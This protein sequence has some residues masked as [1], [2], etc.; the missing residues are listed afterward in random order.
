VGVP[1]GV[2][3]LKT[4]EKRLHRSKKGDTQAAINSNTYN[5]T[6]GLDI[7]WVRLS[8]RE[9]GLN[10]QDSTSIG[11]FEHLVDRV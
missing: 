4:G 5:K 2:L 11:S 3:S 8:R 7:F 9:P 10:L 6:G 1:L